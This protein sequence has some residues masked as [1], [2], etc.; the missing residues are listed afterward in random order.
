[1]RTLLAL[2]ASVGL[3]GC[4]GDVTDM[5]TMADNP[6]TSQDDDNPAG[7]DL[8]AAK[9]NFEAN[10]YP[11]INAKCS[12]AACHSAGTTGGSV[13]KFVAADI[14]T[15]HQTATEYQALVGNFTSTAAPILTLVKAGHKAVT[16]TPTEEQKIVDWLDLEVAARNGQTGGTGTGGGG[17]ETLSQATERVLS[18]F[19]GC[20]AQTDW[21]AANMKQA[22]GR[23]DSENNTE[24]VDCHATGYQGFIASDTNLFYDVVSTKKYYFLQY[25][26]VD[27]TMGASAAK[28]VMNPASILGVSNAQPPH[29]EHPRINANSRQQGEAALTQFYNATMTKVSANACQPKPLSNN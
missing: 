7:G 3:V 16:Y 23:M 17:G 1:M 5:P 6:N 24:C 11:I 9:M 20:M 22:W 10:V 2:I 25:L 19:A 8:T 12:G 15:A 29:Q 18:Q 4:V 27:L 21:D 13:T 28:V 14:S 26:T